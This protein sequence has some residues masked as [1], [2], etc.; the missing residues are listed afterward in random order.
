MIV[1]R[2]WMVLV[3]ALLASILVLAPA[4]APDRKPPRIVAATMIDADDDARADRVRLTYSERV[5]HGADRDGRYPFTVTGYRILSV[6]K[7]SGKALVL[8]LAEHDRA[9]PAGAPTIRY[10]RTSN[11]PVKDLAGNQARTRQFIRTKPHGHQLRPAPAPTPLDTDGDGTPDMDDCAPKDAAVHP[12]AA[13]EPDLAFVDSNCDAIDGTETDAIFVSPDG[14][15]TNPGTKTKPVREIATA[16]SA[17]VSTRRRYVLVAFGT[18][19][20]V[21]LASGI[22][23]YGGYDATSWQRRDRFLGELPRIEGSPDGVLAAGAKDVVLQHLEISGS[24]GAGERSAYGI[25]AISGASLTLQ[26]VAIIAGD[27]ATGTP[28]ATGATGTSGGAGGAG[29]V[30]LCDVGGEDVPGGSSGQSPAARHIGGRGGDGGQ[31]NAGRVGAPGGVGAT[32]VG[33]KAPGGAGGDAGN[34]GKPGGKGARG[35]NG[36]SGTA[37]A[38]GTSSP[39]LTGAFWLGRKGAAGRT[40]KP[41]NGGGGGGGG[42]GQTG[43]FVTDGTG[44]GGGGGGGG[45][46]GGTGGAGGNAAGGSFGLWLIDSTI[47]VGASSIEAGAGG[48]GGRGGDGGFGGVGGAGGNGGTRCTSEVGAGGSGGFG[49]AGGRGGGGGGGAGGPSIGIFKIGA[50]TVTVQGDSKISIGNPGQGGA[51]GRSGPG[52]TGGDGEAGTARAIESGGP[53]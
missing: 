49:G 31:S 50:S 15:D 14:L 11:Q 22:S 48:A 28:G 21:E 20:R 12:G 5:R 7:A 8:L 44:N 18:Y 34:P 24:S 51:G 37:G 27:G 30:G 52:S 10:R 46:N 13:D 19:K 29:S 25:R 39:Q 36:A 53:A 17:A 9:D 43:A 16:V 47:V 4:A 3:G 23:I 35:E 26:R 2:L 32:G 42:G 41:G 38:G 33:D 6:G 40:G 45:G 1:S